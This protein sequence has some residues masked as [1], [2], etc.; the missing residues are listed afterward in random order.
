MNQFLFLKSLISCILGN[1]KLF[2]LLKNVRI[3]IN[4]KFNK[5]PNA[6]FELNIDFYLLLT[7][8]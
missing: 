6:N 5:E 2:L 4:T 1:E 8:R 7:L 3:G